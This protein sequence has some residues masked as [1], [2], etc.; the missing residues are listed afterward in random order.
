[1]KVKICCIQSI[2]EAQLAIDYGAHAIGLVGRMP[3]GPGPIPD[4][5][6]AEIAD[7]A[8]EGLETFL[9]TSET[10]AEDIIAHHQRTRTTTIQLVDAVPLDAFRKIRAVLR[11]IKLVQVIHV[12][13]EASV[14]EAQKVAPY[15]DG[16]LL[17]S[18]NP[19]A[20][21]KELGGTGR[22]HNWQFSRQIV[23]SVEIPVFLAGGLKA[24]NVA[25]AIDAVEPYGVD[26]CSGIRDNGLLNPDNLADFMQ[27]ALHDSV[28]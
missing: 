15:V 26:L 27:V 10:T 24:E 2:Q 12:I 9:L 4:Q 1:M 8:P 13:D 18:G 17:D 5:R 16:L 14:V 22:V 7:W 23:K 6:I 3:S 20:R 21:I 28:R 25:Q 11:N 19:K